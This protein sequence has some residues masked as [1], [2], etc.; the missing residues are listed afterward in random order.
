M[1]DNWV[2]DNL[3]N[4]TIGDKKIMRNCQC[5]PAARDGDYLD[6]ELIILK[7]AMHLK[8]KSNVGKLT[9]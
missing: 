3:V 9:S 1:N 8:R 5:N 7:N 4:T 2:N 6:I